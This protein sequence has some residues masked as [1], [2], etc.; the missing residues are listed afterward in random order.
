MRTSAALLAVSIAA[1]ADA[2]AKPIRAA[3]LSRT[4]L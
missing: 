4:S 1:A 3:S 2:H